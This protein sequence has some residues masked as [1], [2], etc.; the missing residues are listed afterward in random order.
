MWFSLWAIS[1]L[2]ILSIIGAFF[3]AEKAKLLFN[4][5]PLIILWF[6]L[7]FLLIAGIFSYPKLIKSPGLFMMHLGGIF[8]LI[9][10]MTGSQ[11]GIKLT[12]RL[13]NQHKFPAGFMAI[14]QGQTENKVIIEDPLEQYKQLPFDIKLRDFRIEYYPNEIGIKNFSS[15][16]TVI[17]NQK[18]VLDAS[19]RVN[20]P[21]H[22]DGFH[23]YQNSYNLQPSPYT[24]LQVVADNGLY[25]VY[26]GYFLFCIGVFWHFWLPRTG[27]NDVH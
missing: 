17:Q 24:I 8:I 16:V 9:G 21:L 13:F 15:D 14:Y 12:N 10:G 6:I 7:L 25:I 23:I 27:A 18:N 4:S 1:Q 11:L 3:G 26:T 19:I 5:P 2:I 22:F 20:H